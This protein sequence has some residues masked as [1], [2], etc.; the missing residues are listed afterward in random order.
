MPKQA[1]IL[2]SAE[3]NHRRWDACVQH[4]ASGLIYAQTVYLNAM[5]PQWHG[6]VIND[7]EAVMAIPW[8]MKF[9]FRY[10]YMPA[11]MQQLG[12]MGQYDEADLKAVVR[13][14]PD[15]LS[16]GNLYFNFSNTGTLAYGASSKTN[17]VIDLQKPIAQI[18]AGYR[19]DL[20]ENIRKAE[21]MGLSYTRDSQIATAVSQYRE[22]Y[23]ARIPQTKAGD[24]ERFQNLCIAL[25]QTENCFTRSVTDEQGELL[26]IALF[27]KDDNR[28]YNLMNTTVAAGRKKEANH[29]LLDK[30]IGEFEGQAL[31]F[32][33]EGS[34]LAGV[35][36]FY[37]QFGATTE[38]YFHYHHNSLPWWLRL[39]KR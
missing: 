31:V 16:Y 38:P 27:L 32:D 28:I 37:Q 22:H 12:L 11:F 26:A 7:Y 39:F 33:F 1:Y 24:Y 6:I 8:R 18:R 23:A 20:K 30:V 10:A 9:G 19:S 17:L 14:L 34:E 2:P 15:F 29:F 21:S 4:A 36:A 13:T 5:A 25:L 35:K 3:I